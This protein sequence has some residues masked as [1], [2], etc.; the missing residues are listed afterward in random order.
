[1]SSMYRDCTTI[2]RKTQAIYDRENR[3][4][5]VIAKAFGVSDEVFNGG[6]G[7]GNSGK[8]FCNYLTAQDKKAGNVRNSLSAHRT[9]QKGQHK[10]SYVAIS[11]TMSVAT[12]ETISD[13]SAED[14]GG[15]GDSGPDQPPEPPEPPRQHP[16]LI[17]PQKRNSFIHSWRT[18]PGYCSMVGGGRI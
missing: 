14:D 18:T 13:D 2:S 12:T 11:P 6:G 8:S 4:Q 10:V 3:K 1:M 17:L 16:Y 5:R 7:W 15:G 9:T